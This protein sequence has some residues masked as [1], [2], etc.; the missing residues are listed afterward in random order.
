MHFW[1]NVK[2][3]LLDGVGAIS[4]E[5]GVGITCG[6]NHFFE[7]GDDYI[8]KVPIS[9]FSSFENNAKI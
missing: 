6:H 2:L 9:S 3:E 4:I 5:K 1:N 8:K 7:E